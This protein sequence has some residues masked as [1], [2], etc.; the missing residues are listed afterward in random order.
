[1]CDMVMDPAAGD[2]RVKKKRSRKRGT[3]SQDCATMANGS[4]G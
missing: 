3:L 4:K 2:E 1:M